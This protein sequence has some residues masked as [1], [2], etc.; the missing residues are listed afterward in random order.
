MS[1]CSY[2]MASKMIAINDKYV[3]NGSNTFYGYF[4]QQK[5]LSEYDQIL[6]FDTTNFSALTFG[7]RQIPNPIMEHSIATDAR[8]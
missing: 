1:K 2:S 4:V 8:T 6:T 3:K 5:L 7:C